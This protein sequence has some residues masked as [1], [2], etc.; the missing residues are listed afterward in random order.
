[1]H[2]DE[3]APLTSMRLASQTLITMVTKVRSLISVGG[4]HTN[5][6]VC[7]ATCGAHTAACTGR[8][9]L[10][11]LEG[12]AQ[13]TSLASICLYASLSADIRNSTAACKYD[14]STCITLHARGASAKCTHPCALRVF[15]ISKLQNNFVENGLRSSI[16]S[17]MPYAK[18]LSYQAADI[19]EL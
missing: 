8:L 4:A 14:L 2:A 1:M 12:A 13:R 9:C 16:P 17:I 7:A 6:G 15:V 11:A 18:V 5:T 10:R 3:A 19:V